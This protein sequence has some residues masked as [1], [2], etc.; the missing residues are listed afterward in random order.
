MDKVSVIIPAYNSQ[1]SII[2][3]IESVLKQTHRNIE[4]IVVDDG[5]VDA[6]KE[7]VQNYQIQN[8]IAGLRLI[9]KKNGGPSSA[10]NVG[11]KNAQGEYIAFLDSD[12]EWLPRKIEC[13]LQVFKENPQIVI[14]GTLVEGGAVAADDIYVTFQKMLFSNR[15]ITSSVLCRREALR[16]LK[17]NEKQKYSEDYRLFLQIIFRSGTGIIINKPLVKR[18]DKKI[19][20]EKG[21]SASLW[22]MEKGEL[23]NYRDLKRKRQISFSLYIGIV[24]YSFLKFIRRLFLIFIHHL[25][26]KK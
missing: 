19:F 3:C 26:K 20:G 11:I 6:T 14:V 5:S 21:L 12:D 2:P 8:E 16:N 23:S 10:R 13:Q 18:A 24:T 22:K 1:D 17:F 15:F 25:L 7:F 4:I 9:S